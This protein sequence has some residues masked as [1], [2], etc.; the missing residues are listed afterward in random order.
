MKKAAFVILLPAMILTACSSAGSSSGKK[1]DVS[2]VSVE[3]GLISGKTN[4]EGSVSIFMGI[5]YASAPVGELRWKAPVPPVKWEGVRQCVTPPPSA[6]QSKPAPFMMWSKEFMAPEEPLSEDCLFL[7]IWTPAKNTAEKLPV[8]VWIHGGAFT[9]GSGTVPLYDGEEM[10]KKGVVFIT[11]NYRLGVFGFL[12]HTEL[13]A[14]SPLKT[15]GNY[16]ILDQIEALKWISR[17]IEAFGGDPGN[18]TIAGQSAGSFS[19]NA[20][21]ISPL[22]KGL[23]HRAIGQS[24]GM[25]SGSLGL[26]TDLKAAET[27]GARF[28]RHFS[29]STIAGL[30]AL[31]AEEL[32]KIPGRWGVTTDNIVVQSATAAF[33][34]GRQNDVPL[35]AGW[36]ADD[37]VSM[38]AS[39]DIKTYIRNAESRYGEMASEYLKLFPANNEAE[40][41][42]S[43]KLSSV[44][45]FGWQNYTWAGM[46]TRTGKNK[47]YLYYFTHVPPGE[48]NYG[49]FHS[50][51]FGYALN[52]LKLWDRP[53]SDADYRLAELMSSYWVNFARTGDPNGEGMPEWPAFDPSSPR[54]IEFGDEVTSVPLPFREQL[55]FYD[56]LNK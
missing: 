54:I 11:I 49:A 38:G 29:D 15:S 42:N 4:P 46:Q 8:M 47:A 28:A 56:R 50:A 26:V 5:P 14:E 35:I 13:T 16:G 27:A 31:S 41:L 33:I 17:N 2:K 55:E 30:R 40:V 19:V 36:N 20:L 53:F 3:S 1:I 39:P 12:A 7:N 9:G 52:T 24:G 43:L 18:V 37:G 32:M 10:A 25:F 22:A 23:F 45:S 44:L 51:E 48:P 21:M 6:M 34:E